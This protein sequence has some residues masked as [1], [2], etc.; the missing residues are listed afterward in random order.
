MVLKVG[1]VAAGSPLA[2]A[3]YKK[4]L[5]KFK[6]PVLQQLIAVG[7]ITAEQLVDEFTAEY[8]ESDE[9]TINE[10]FRR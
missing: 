4:V 2:K 6:D 1:Q 7:L 5:Q 8:P 3:V 9:R 10:C